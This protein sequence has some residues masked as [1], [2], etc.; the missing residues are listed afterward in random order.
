[1]SDEYKRQDRQVNEGIEKAVSAAM[2]VLLSPQKPEQPDL[3]DDELNQ[4]VKKLEDR[5]EDEGE[6]IW[7]LDDVENVVEEEGF[8]FG[9]MEDFQSMNIGEVD[10][11]YKE[12][13]V[14]AVNM[15]RAL[16]IVGFK[17]V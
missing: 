3:T 10:I 8:T 1:M 17:R 15:E 9:D 14:A 2:H 13:V 11:L 4:K 5:L 7:S 6:P 16:T 12:K